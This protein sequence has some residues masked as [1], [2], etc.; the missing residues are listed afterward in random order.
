MK[1]LMINGSPRQASNTGLALK[2]MAEALSRRDID[3]EILQVGDSAIPGCRAC[4]A[5]GRLGR[6]AID[7]VV[8]EIAL[9]LSD[10]DGLVLGSP[11]YYAGPNSTLTALCD[12]LFYS[13][14]CDLSMKVGAAVVCARRGGTT[15]AF[16]RL[17]KYFT[18]SGMPVAS[19]YYWNNV[20]GAAPGEALQDG[21]GMWN[22]RCLAENM[23][24][25]M[26]SIALG[27]EKLGL[28]DREPGVRTNFIR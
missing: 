14:G 24:F 28:P 21:E 1:V 3:S 5:C 27:K 19:G 10:A 11:V 26:K 2:E 22:V 7:D 15:A 25:L 13:C 16:D 20:H 18:I 9:R 8:N 23:A 12:R 4:G 17:N 6:C